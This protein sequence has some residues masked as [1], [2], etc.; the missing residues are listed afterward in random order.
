MTPSNSG[1]LLARIQGPIGRSLWYFSKVNHAQ[2]MDSPCGD[3][4]NNVQSSQF[5]I[6]LTSECVTNLPQNQPDGPTQHLV[7][8]RLKPILTSH[9]QTLYL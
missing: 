9:P 4:L 8:W 2:P 1:S 5:Y 7:R 3:G 6:Y